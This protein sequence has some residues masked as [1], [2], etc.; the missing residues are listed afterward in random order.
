M[1]SATAWQTLFL[2]AVDGVANVV[3]YLFH[4][5]LGRSLTP[6]DFAIVQTVNSMFLIVGTAFAVFQPVVARYVAESA[7]L[8]DAQDQQRAIFQLYLKLSAVAGVALAAVLWLGR[9][10][11]AAW[12]HVPVATVTL[13]SAAL[14]FFLMRPVVSGMLQGRQRF[15]AFGLT[16]SSYAFAR[17]FLVLVF[18]GVLGGGAVAAVATMPLAGSIALVIGLLLLGVGVWQQSSPAAQTAAR[19]QLSAAWRLSLAAFL[20]YVAY[21][22]LLNLD[23]IFANRLFPDAVSGSYAT[24]VVLRRVMSV[25]PGAVLVVFYPR[26]AALVARHELP[27]RSL[28]KALAV[29]VAT[30]SLLMAVYFLWG[31][32]LVPVVFG[33]G[34]DLA[35]PLLGWMGVGMIGYGITAVW[36][37]L[38]LATRPW[39]YSVAL[40][41]IV[42][43]QALAYSTRVQS[44]Q[45]LMAVFVAGGWAA[46]L[47]GTA[48]YGLWL[49]PHLKAGATVAAEAAT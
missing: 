4:V 29:I 27:D 14:V 35:G 26:V 32:W 28:A 47:L 43:L 3:D 6:G 36:M 40:V 39:P 7:E 5:F 23:V 17:F 38:F 49:R 41:V 16:R 13:A 20:A 9:A 10:A 19:S 44:P 46:A 33:P 8:P 24:A 37:N 30:T 1:L 48:L 2:F 18:V 22:T 21:M 25:L 15:V 11:V 42:A 45:G 34:Y 12:L 31:D